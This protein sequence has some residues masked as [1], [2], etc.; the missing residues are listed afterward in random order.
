M[1]VVLILL[2]SSGATKLLS[3]ELYRVREA[4]R[5]ELA[6]R[7]EEALEELERAVRA[8]DPEKALAAVGLLA[9]LGEKALPALE[10]ALHSEDDAVAS[11]AWEAVVRRRGRAWMGVSIK[12]V[13][14]PNGEPVGGG[15]LV[16]EVKKN[17]PAEESGMKAGDIIIGFNGEEALSVSDLI[18]VVGGTRPGTRC[19]VE[20]IRSGE[21]VEVELKV[22]TMPEEYLRR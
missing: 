9:R 19:R 22:T 8:E 10:E 18:R 21:P 12:D 17:T 7:G 11:A 2:C 5:R 15:A 20:L 4:A 14:G 16:A 6:E 13:Q 1:T 3:H